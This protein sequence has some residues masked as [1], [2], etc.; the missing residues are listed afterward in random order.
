[1]REEYIYMSCY[2]N[3]LEPL[4]KKLEDELKHWKFS[5][6]EWIIRRTVIP[7]YAFHKPG[8]LYVFEVSYNVS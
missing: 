4:M 8:L 6:V 2:D 1:M 5:N 3:I 7:E